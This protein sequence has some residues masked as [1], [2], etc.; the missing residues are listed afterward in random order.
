[1][2]ELEKGLPRGTLQT[3]PRKPH[4]GGG[5]EDSSTECI[6]I[7][8]DFSQ[9]PTCSSLCS[10]IFTDTVFD[11]IEPSSTGSHIAFS[12]AHRHPPTNYLAQQVHFFATVKPYQTS[13]SLYR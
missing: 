2:Q 3:V 10:P 13:A 4:K 11:Y 7:I 8:K 12:F 6:S 5:I 9:T 1:M